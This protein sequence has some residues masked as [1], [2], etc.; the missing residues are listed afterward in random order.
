MNKNQFLYFFPI[1]PTLSILCNECHNAIYSYIGRQIGLAKLRERR[2]E[3]ANCCM[4]NMMK[5]KLLFTVKNLNAIFACN[6]I[7]KG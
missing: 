6:S 7:S 4:Q 2:E 3:A 1:N 5:T